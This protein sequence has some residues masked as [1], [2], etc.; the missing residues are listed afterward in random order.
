MEKKDKR[1]KILKVSG[2]IGLFLIVFGLS[3]ALF[4]VTLNGTK[5]VKIKTGKLELQLLDANNNPIYTTGGNTTT[6]YEI[7]LDNQVPVSDETG[8]GTQAFEFKLKNT[9]NIKA[10]YTIYLDDVALESGES[11]I[12]DEYIRYSITKNGSSDSAQA[13]TSR[14]LD[15]GTIEADNTTNEYTLKI[16]IAEDATNEAMDKVFNATLRVEGTQYIPEKSPYGTKIAETQL[17]ETI[18]A[19]Y[20]QSEETSYNTNKVKRMSNVE[21]I[22]NEE[23]YEGGTLVISGEGEIPDYDEDNIS[24]VMLMLADVSTSEEFE[25]LWDENTDTYAFKYYPSDMII[26]EGIT[27]VGD[28]AF[29]CMPATYVTIPSSIEIIGNGAFSCSNIQNVLIEEGLKILGNNAFG[30]SDLISIELPNSLEVIGSNAFS[31][32]KSLTSIIL[33]SGVKT[34]GYGALM[35]DSLETINLPRSIQNLTSAVLGGYNGHLKTIYCETQE[36][37]DLISTHIS[38][39]PAMIGVTQIIVDPTKFE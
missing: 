1:K 13:L 3:Y 38:Y 33:G 4:T 30:G 17:T 5:K 27:R 26:E 22:D 2:L 36:V 23:T 15:K 10:S 21:K 12:D 6:S 34:I 7:N 19:T 29:C 35:A 11:R 14:E 31:N 20:Y 16:W 37:A 18:T 8:L 25:K 9:G 39:G 28:F 32:S 24:V